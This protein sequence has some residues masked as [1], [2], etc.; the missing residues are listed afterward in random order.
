MFDLKKEKGRWRTR[1][2]KHDRESFGPGEGH[3]GG[4]FWRD[5]VSKAALYFL[6]FH[7]LVLIYPVGSGCMC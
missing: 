7:F 1:L 3:A 5:T 2:E 6:I 4:G